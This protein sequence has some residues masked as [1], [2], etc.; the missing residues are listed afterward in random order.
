MYAFHPHAVLAFGILVHA[1]PC[2]QTRKNNRLENAVVLCSRMML[3]VPLLGLF[4]RA[5]GAETVDPANLKRLMREGRDIA[6]LP[7]GF[8]EATLT[9]PKELR[10]YIN[11]RKGFMKYA[12]EFGYQVVP[13]LV[14]N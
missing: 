1:N 3:I 6:L 11:S 5:M 14:T 2:P 12:M 8:E 10:V 9:T 13:V 4:L 7:G